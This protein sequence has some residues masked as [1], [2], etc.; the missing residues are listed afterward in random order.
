MVPARLRRNL[1]ETLVI[2]RSRE[3]RR[4]T[5]S[6]PFRTLGSMLKHTQKS[7]AA[8]RTL[9]VGEEPLDDSPVSI[10]RSRAFHLRNE[11]PVPMKTER[12]LFEL[13]ELASFLGPD[14]EL[15]DERD[16][17]RNDPLG[18][19]FPKFETTYDYWGF[20]T[21]EEWRQ[22]LMDELEWAAWNRKAVLA[23]RYPLYM[24]GWRNTAKWLKAG[25]HFGTITSFL[26]N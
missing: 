19:K 16:A 5:P 20:H 7:K 10:T 21:V 26:G 8:R 22:I 1:C 25:F 3:T 6:R 12:R 9:F 4:V 17:I 18:H 15:L 24:N 23:A 13:C 11:A 14:G 2:D